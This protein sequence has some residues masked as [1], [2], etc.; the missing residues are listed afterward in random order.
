MADTITEPTADQQL[1]ELYNRGMVRAK[2][3][4]LATNQLYAVCLI[5]LNNAVQPSDYPAIGAAI[6]AVTGVQGIQLLM[7]H[8]TRA[9][10]P[11]DHELR[12]IVEANLRIDPLPVAG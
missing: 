2:S 1:I 5:Q 4:V 8:K 7:D 12:L 3:V 10:I 9:T 6:N 11:A